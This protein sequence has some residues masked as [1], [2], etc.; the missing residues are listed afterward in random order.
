MKSFLFA[1]LLPFFAVTALTAA[2]PIKVGEVASL[3]G[4]EAAFGN[5]SH[6]G[7]LLAIE[8]LNAAGG[9]LGRP[10]ELL[11][12]DNQSKAGESA[13][14]ARKLVSREKV[15]ALLGE[16]ASSRS[17]EMAP[18]AQR[19]KIPM[20]SPSSTNP[21]VTAVGDY[22]FRVCFIDPFQGTVMAKYAKE[23]LKAKRVA[24]VT[25]VSSAYSVGL[26]K[27]FKERFVADGG[28]IALEQKFAEG[29]KDFKAQLTAIRAAG[30]DAIFVP[31]YYTEAALITRQAR[32]LGLTLPLFGGDGW[33]A[34]QLLEIG[35]AAMN[36]T[37][38]S[39]HY[40]PEDSSPKVQSFVAAFRARWNGE[41]PDAM[42]ALGYDSAMVL[43]DAITRAKTV[44]AAAV[45]DALAA[46]KG[47][48]GVTGITT[49]DADRNASKAASIITVQ[50]GKFKF[51]QSVAP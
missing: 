19:A 21:K 2:E 42:A 10:V 15:V 17:L 45:R 16:V 39:T 27:Y 26:A 46:T 44:E 37:Y 30:V 34:P 23:N 6:Q 51:V 36:G 38:Y 5:A 31:G 40:S 8:Q 25:S 14:V 48:A 28:E 9:V 7:T 50:N 35:G 1:S 32:E 3:T 24:V 4:K 11:T 41:T 22:I 49:L 13:T 47:Y 33:E 43:A 20:I 18:I 12:E 29:D